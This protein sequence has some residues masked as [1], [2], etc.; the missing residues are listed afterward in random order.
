MAQQWK[1]GRVAMKAVLAAS[2]AGPG[3]VTLAGCAGGG[4]DGG[5]VSQP[6]PPAPP[7]PV[8]SPPPAPPPPASPPVSPPASPPPFPNQVASPASFETIEYSNASGL[9]RINASDA[10]SIGATGQGIRVA[11]IDTGVEADHPDLQGQVVS[12]FDI[13]ASSRSAGD[14]DQEGHATLVAGVAAAR[15]DDSGVHGVAFGSEIISIRADDP[16]SCGAPDANDQSGCSYFDSDLVQAIDLAVSEGA[17]I[18]NLSLGGEIDNDPSLE[19]AIRNAASAGV[20][21]VISAGNEAA[22]ATTDS[23]GNIQP[24][25]GQSPNEPAFIAGQAASLGRVVAVGSIDESGVISD[26]S[27]RAGANAQS[28]YMLAPGEGVVSTGP[29]DDVVFPGDSQNDADSIGDFYRVS[30]TSFAAPHVSGALA[31]LLQTFPNLQDAP[32]DA[33]AILL[34]TADDYVDASPDAVAGV[35]AGVGTDVV[36]GV[37]SL[38]LAAAFSPIGQQT[39]SLGL[40]RMD[41]SAALAPTGGALGDWASHSGA[42]DGLVFQDSYD[43]AFRLDAATAERALSRA[44]S[45]DSRL[46]DLEARA[47]WQAGQTRAVQVADFSFSWHEPALREDPSAPYQEEPQSTFQARYAFD[48]G[49]VEFGRGGGLTPIAPTISLVDEPG[50]GSVLSTGGSWARVSHSLGPVELDVFA[51]DDPWRRL[52]GVGVSKGG[53]RWIVRGALSNEVDWTSAAGGELQSRFGESEATRALA[54]TLEGAVA[55]GPDWSLAGGMEAAS[56]SLPGVYAKGLWTSR[57]SA[58]LT[59]RL[60]AGD[61]SLAIAQPR[62]AESG[63]LVFSAPYAI[64]ARGDLLFT[65]VTAGLTPSG[66]QIDYETRYRFALGGGWTG[67]TAFAVSTS[68]NHVA[69]AGR[70]EAAWFSVKTD[71]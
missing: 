34:Q 71:W 33:L 2:L 35:A 16:G 29:D 62:R 70:E 37:G 24:A 59:R 47:E 53:P 9:A 42:F 30:G 69:G 1:P 44:P 63:D 45:P 4:S 31:L 52:S 7:P 5:T 26:F 22:P 28:F 60:A 17:D 36:G 56:L 14:I 65:D 15:K 25:T 11:V 68:P 39:L 32:E 20:L 12:T 67:E 6:L 8:S 41:L 40:Q 27:N 61:W 23:S 48:G 21:F 19:N 10:Y 55:L 51:A 57:W 43:R 66:R 18:I 64:D 50:A 13:N 49:H 58:G 46:A 54:Y 3:L 38:N